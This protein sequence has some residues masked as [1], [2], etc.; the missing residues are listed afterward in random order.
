MLVLAGPVENLFVR[1]FR[2]RQPC[3]S[4]ASWRG[5]PSCMRG[6]R[7]CLAGRDRGRGASAYGSFALARLLVIGTSFPLAT[8]VLVVDRLPRRDH[9]CAS[10]AVSLSNRPHQMRASS[11]TKNVRNG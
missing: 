8:P 1:V 2:V 5:T 6:P 10:D 7:R 11:K 3:G 9:H 4:L